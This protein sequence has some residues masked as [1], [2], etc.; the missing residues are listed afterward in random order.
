MDVKPE[1]LFPSTRLEAFSDG[2]L[3]IVITLLVLEL[4]VP[5]SPD[6]LFEDLV[7]E[8]PSFLAYLVSFAF[9][10]GSW[11]A[12]SNVTALL[13]STDGLFSRLNLLFLL[14]VSFLPFTT[15]LM[16]THSTDD[17]QRIAVVAFGLN[18]TLGALMVNALIAYAGRGLADESSRSQLSALGKERLFV[19]ALL[20][21]STVAAA[22]IP[23]IAALLYL[24]ASLLILVTPLHMVRRSRREFHSR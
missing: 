4:H 6:R 10:G 8:W 16:A 3:A 9:V 19:A 23:K 13:S 12:H 18:L 7:A 17:G 2:V 14:S 24:A 20:A 15:S 22:V 11:V 5:E 1:R 21:L